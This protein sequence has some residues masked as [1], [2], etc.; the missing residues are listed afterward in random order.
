MGIGSNYYVEVAEQ[1]HEEALRKEIAQDA[2]VDIVNGNS[3]SASIKAAE[4]RIAAQQEA[5]STGAYSEN[6][7]GIVCFHDPSIESPVIPKGK[8]VQVNVI[9]EELLEQL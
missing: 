9:A 4:E 8:E 1:E 6:E 3:R 5:F 2:A 7:D